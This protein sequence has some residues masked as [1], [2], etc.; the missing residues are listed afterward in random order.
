MQEAT[1]QGST[2]QLTSLSTASLFWQALGS[3]PFGTVTY[4]MRL[5]YCTRTEDTFFSN[6]PICQS[7]L[8]AQ[9]L[10]LVCMKLMLCIFP[11]TEF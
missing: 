5:L 11:Q 10:V 4:A 1:L 8:Y 2:V 9:L 7:L 3:D 6:N